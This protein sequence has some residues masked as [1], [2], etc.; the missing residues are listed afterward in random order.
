MEL[1]LFWLWMVI[2][3]CTMIALFLRATYFQGRLEAAEAHIHI[4]THPELGWAVSIDAY[5]SCQHESDERLAEL[6]RI[7][8]WWLEENPQ[9][10]GVDVVY[11]WDHT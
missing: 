9:A 8:K 7:R 10:E 11:P 5:E 1:V 3:M 6:R 4:A 2:V